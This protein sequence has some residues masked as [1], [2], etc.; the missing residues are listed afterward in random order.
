MLANCIEQLDVT[1]VAALACLTQLHEVDSQSLEWS[2]GWFSRRPSALELVK[3]R[4]NTRRTI[5]PRW[6]FSAFLDLHTVDTLLKL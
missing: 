4:L 6:C 3:L 5:L 2:G 1:V